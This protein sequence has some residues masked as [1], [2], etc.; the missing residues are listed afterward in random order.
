MASSITFHETTHRA[1][2]EA[3][4]PSNIQGSPVQADNEPRLLFL[5]SPGP[6]NSLNGVAN[7]PLPALAAITPERQI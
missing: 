3:S 6:E 5:P 4:G 1:I 7:G 2:V